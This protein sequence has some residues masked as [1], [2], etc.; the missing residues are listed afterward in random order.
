MT[1]FAPERLW[2]LVVVGLVALGYLIVAQRRR[3]YS[4]RL[5]SAHLLDSV[6]PKRPSWRRH[7][8]AISQLAALAVLVL[9]VARP[10]TETNVPRERAT[11]VVAI[12]VSLSMAATDVEPSRLLAAQEAA[13]RFVEQLP[14]TLNVGIVA[15][16]GHASIL[17][18]PTL[19]RPAAMRA[20][21][22]LQL[23]ESTAIG[24]AIFVSLDAL[25]ATPGAMG[26]SDDVPPARI[27]LLS[28]GE[29]T[30]GR[31]DATAVAAAIEANVPVS[32]IAFGTLGGV[33]MFDNP[34]TP[35]VE[36][37]PIPVPVREDNLEAIARDTGGSFFAAESL[38]EL[39][40]VYADIGSAIGYERELTDI[41]DRFAAGAFALFV[42]SSMLTMWWFGRVL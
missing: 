19:D 38:D 10:A 5:A 14:P 37:D 9:A 15:F 16:A 30:V 35:E 40:E 24:E 23:S 26:D 21:D 34:D 1:F 39:D 41:S 17:V 13:K 36:Q 4:A 18:P 28:D 20:I 29:T 6:L 32:T 3:V 22:N 8:L 11:I 2:L 25:A 42:G 12:D 31:P 33:I 7:V 27:V